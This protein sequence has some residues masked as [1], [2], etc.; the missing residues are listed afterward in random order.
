MKGAIL[1][2]QQF[3]NFLSIAAFLQVDFG[4]GCRVYLR[5]GKKTQG[6]LKCLNI[7]FSLFDFILVMLYLA[8]LV[9]PC[10]IHLT[11]TIK[12]H[13]SYTIASMVN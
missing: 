12:Y 6:V 5:A 2:F 11:L 7:Y 4:R 8:S 13:N 9:P 1:F 3:I 10:K